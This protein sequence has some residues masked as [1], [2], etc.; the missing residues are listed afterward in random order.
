M[1]SRNYGAR[2]PQGAEW[3]IGK[4]AASIKFVNDAVRYIETCQ[5][6]QD[7]GKLLG[8]VEK[9]KRG[10][11]VLEASLDPEDFLSQE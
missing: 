2:P 7:R 3:Q 1:T 11:M 10:E 9:L 8:A 4:T 6:E 5:N